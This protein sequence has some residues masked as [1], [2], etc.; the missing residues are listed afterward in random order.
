MKQPMK[1]GSFVPKTIPGVRQGGGGHYSRE[2]H[3]E[4]NCVTF[5]CIHFGNNDCIVDFLTVI[6][7][8]MT[9][10]SDPDKCIDLWQN[11]LIMN[12]VTF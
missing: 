10:P 7:Q 11:S 3:K 1:K 5:N 2:Y 4:C 6:Y 8:Q 12:H 9:G